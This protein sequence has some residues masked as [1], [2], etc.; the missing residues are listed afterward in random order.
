MPKYREEI[1]AVCTRF[2]LCVRIAYMRTYIERLTRFF[3]FSMQIE[4]KMPGHFEY[5]QLFLHPTMT[6]SQSD[7]DAQVTEFNRFLDSRFSKLFI[8]NKVCNCISTR[9]SYAAGNLRPHKHHIIIFQFSRHE[10][11]I[12]LKKVYIIYLWGSLKYVYKKKRAT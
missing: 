7:K 5:I 1:R 4:K 11:C 12:F 8:K 2:Y 3:G 6:F 9:R 10:K